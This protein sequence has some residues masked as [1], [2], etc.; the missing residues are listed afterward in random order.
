MVSGFECEEVRAGGGTS[1]GIL[2][3]GGVPLQSAGFR[4]LPVTPDVGFLSSGEATGRPS[5]GTTLLGVVGLEW[6]REQE[7]SSRLSRGSAA[8]SQSRGR[9]LPFQCCLTC[10]KKCLE[11]LLIACGHKKLPNRVPL[12]GVDFTQVP[13]DFPEE[14]PFVVVKCTAEIEAR[15]LGVQVSGRSSSLCSPPCPHLLTSP[16]PTRAGHL[17]HQRLQSPG[18]KAVPGV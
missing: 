14:V 6:L 18:G 7:E 15:A 12:F 3:S 16:P 10:H 9:A 4:I 2:G 1:W 13:R 5:P 11:N 8:T 17:P